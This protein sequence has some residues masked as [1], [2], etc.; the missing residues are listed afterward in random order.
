MGAGGDRVGPGFQRPAVD[1]LG[2]VRHYQVRVY[3]YLDAQ[4]V[5]FRAGAV[6]GI[7]REQPRFQFGEADAAG[8]AGVLLAVEGRRLAAGLFHAYETLGLAEGQFHGL[9]EALA[10][11]GADGELVHEQ[12]DI[13]LDVALEVRRGFERT[14]F[15]V[16]LRLGKAALLQTGEQFLVGAAAAAHQ[17]REEPG[18]FAAVLGKYFGGYALRRPGLY[19]LMASRAERAAGL[20]EQQA[21]VVVDLGDGAHGGTRVLGRGMLLDG[22][23]GREALYGIHVGLV[24]LLQELAGVGGQRLH[25][26]ALALGVNS[27]EGERGFAGPRKAGDDHEFILGDLEAEVLEIVRARPAD[28]YLVHIS[29]RTGLSALVLGSGRTSAGSPPCNAVRGFPCGAGPRR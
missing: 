29:S 27:V 17:R 13:V 10:F 3:L 20:C 16:H 26:A 21:Q 19:R 25:V 15:S 23:G 22:D 6:G 7:E 9:A 1:G 2:L 8:G 24:H 4:P 18:L 5:A 11:P 14:H 28:D 12:V